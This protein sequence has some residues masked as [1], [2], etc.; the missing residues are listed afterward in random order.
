[1]VKTRTRKETFLQWLDH[2]EEIGRIPDTMIHLG[3]Y[4]VY[5]YPTRKFQ[6]QQS[7]ATASFMGWLKGYY[8]EEACGEARKP[9]ESWLSIWC[10]PRGYVW[11]QYRDWFGE[12]FLFEVRKI[13]I[14]DQYLK[15]EG[16]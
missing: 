11:D 15:K 8:Y 13:K 3:E 2:L 7:R 5:L 12:G 6:T 9:F 16:M 14:F 10:K 1:M 4:Y